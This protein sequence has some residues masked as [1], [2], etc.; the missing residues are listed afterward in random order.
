MLFQKN[1]ILDQ[2]PGRSNFT[3]F[4]EPAFSIWIEKS[5]G[6][7]IAIIFW[8]LELLILDAFKQALQ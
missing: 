8:D 3:F 4:C 1:Y 5:S 7:I 2:C 6:D